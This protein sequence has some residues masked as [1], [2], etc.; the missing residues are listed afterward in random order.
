MQQLMAPSALQNYQPQNL[1]NEQIIHKL[2]PR[3]VLLL[4]KKYK[5]TN[6]NRWFGF[7]AAFW[8]GFFCLFQKREQCYCKSINSR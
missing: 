2:V 3:L 5:N 1:G 4:I 8:F 6:T 7:V